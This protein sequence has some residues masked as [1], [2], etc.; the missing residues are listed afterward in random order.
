MPAQRE[1]DVLPHR[2]RIEERR[3]LKQKAH[4]LP[5]AGQAAAV[6]RGDVVVLDEHPAR[7]GSHQSD[8]VPQRDALAGS[9]APEQTKGRR[10]WDLERHLVEHPPAAEDLVTAFEANGGRQSINSSI[11]WPGRASAGLRK[12]EEDQPH[13]HDVDDD[14][15][16]R[17]HDD[18]A[19]RGAAHAFGSL[20][21]VSPR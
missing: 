20:R 5:H 6:E 11:S 15:H 3:V 18:A 16:D 19:R 4:P 8:D 21:R 7:V 9:A 10:A 17:R 14:E 13:Q 12:N 2:Q 1:R